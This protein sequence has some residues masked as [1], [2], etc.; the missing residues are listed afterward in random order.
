MAAAT[1]AWTAESLYAVPPAA[2]P[3]GLA[4]PNAD[5]ATTA[6]LARSQQGFW[7]SPAL[8]VVIL[9]AVALGLVSFTIRAGR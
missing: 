8:W 2:E 3:T 9:L 6:P 1:M 4:A 7:S 5:P